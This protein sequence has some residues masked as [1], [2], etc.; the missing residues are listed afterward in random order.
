MRDP[1]TI[2]SAVRGICSIAFAQPSAAWLGFAK[3][4]ELRVLEAFASGQTTSGTSSTLTIHSGDDNSR[5]LFG[6]PLSLGARPRM[7][8]NVYDRL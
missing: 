5:R 7:T 3:L 8:C 2:F 1:N 4:E 6:L